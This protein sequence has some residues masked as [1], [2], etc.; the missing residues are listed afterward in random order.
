MHH[1]FPGEPDALHHALAFAALTAENIG[2]YHPSVL[3]H[4]TDSRCRG[5]GPS[6]PRLARRPIAKTVR[7][8]RQ[9]ERRN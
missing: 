3:S 4:L 8:P 5:A 7:V 2:S 9:N 6:H 1:A